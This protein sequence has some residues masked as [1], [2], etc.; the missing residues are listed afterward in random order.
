MPG[1]ETVARDY[2]LY[3]F[4]DNIT[5]AKLSTEYEKEMTF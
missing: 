1:V 4:M 2:F 5:A 3:A